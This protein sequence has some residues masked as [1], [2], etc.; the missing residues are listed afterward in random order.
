MPRLE[1]GWIKEMATVFYSQGAGKPVVVE[2]LLAKNGPYKVGRWAKDPDGGIPDRCYFCP[3]INIKPA[4]SYIVKDGW[5]YGY[6][7]EHK[8]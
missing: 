3:L 4:I 6:C 8:R 7:E 5:R 1:V 2:D